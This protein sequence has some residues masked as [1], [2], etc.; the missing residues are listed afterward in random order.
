MTGLPAVT[1]YNLPTIPDIVGNWICLDANEHL[2][3]V[4]LSDHVLV[5]YKWHNGF[6]ILYC[7]SLVTDCI[8]LSVQHLLFPFVGEALCFLFGTS[9]FGNCLE[10]T[11]VQTI[12]HKKLVKMPHCR[13]L[14]FPMQRASEDFASSGLVNDEYLVIILG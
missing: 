11:R 1:L 14:T 4:Y 6:H 7:L 8:L 10:T 12:R 3:E 9:K 13:M 5:L 2:Q